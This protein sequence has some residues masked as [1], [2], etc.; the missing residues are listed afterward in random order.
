MKH[1]VT[2]T[3]QL[4]V[5]TLISRKKNQQNQSIFSW[6]IDTGHRRPDVGDHLLRLVRCLA[7][8][9]LSWLVVTGTCFHSVGKFIPS[10]ELTFFQRGR[11]A[12]NSLCRF[13]VITCD[14][15]GFLMVSHYIFHLLGP[16]TAGHSHLPSPCGLV[17]T[18]RI[19]QK[20]HIMYSRSLVSPI[21]SIHMYIYIYVY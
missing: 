19:H 21:S 5:N 9:C 1:H 18:I 2:K 11:Y 13:S 7:W 16:K 6:S 3:S 15:H 8:A 17:V 20:H 4:G 14:N 12:T 10:D